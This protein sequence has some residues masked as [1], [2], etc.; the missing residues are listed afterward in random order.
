MRQ[1]AGKHVSCSHVSMFFWWKT[2]DAR[3]QREGAERIR[4]DMTKRV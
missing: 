1:T 3:H 2:Y 4:A